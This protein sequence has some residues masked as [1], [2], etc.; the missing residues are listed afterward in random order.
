[1]SGLRPNGGGVDG[2]AQLLASARAR[3]SAAIADLALP[4]PLRLS[5]RQRATVSKLL[6]R[7]LREVEDELRSAVAARLPGD[8]HQAVRAALTSATLPI[9]APVL[10]QSGWVAGPELIAILLRRTEE[11]RLSRL[12]PEGQLLVDLAGEADSAI[13]AQA[14]SLLVAH[15]RRFD[16]FQEPLVAPTDLPAEVEHGLIWSVAAALRL[17]L[18]LHQALP[19]PVADEAI[20][21]AAAALVSR[22]DEG[23]GVDALATRL[24]LR[25]HE[26]DRLDDDLLLRVTLEGALP[27]LL[28]GLSLRT[29]L[30]L[31]SAWDL[32]SD[33]GGRG[34]ALLIRAAGVGRK[35]AAAILLHLSG[36]EDEILPQMEAYDAL[37][38]EEALRL[39]GL[40]RMDAAYRGAVSSMAA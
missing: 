26:R 21:A 17:Y 35:A 7:L 16:A 31:P 6:E 2:G 40:W 11:H 25:L 33:A 8:E 24:A 29:A 27:L 9:G 10:E 15:S 36:R 18:V 39:L 38:P 5:D 19:A 13:A 14:V 32:L 28:A 12:A 1:M 30:D 23:A 20:G 3:L 34:P 22:H 37:S 4:E